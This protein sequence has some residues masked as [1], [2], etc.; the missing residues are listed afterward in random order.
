M[1]EEPISGGS[2]RSRKRKHLCRCAA[3][4]RNLVGAQRGSC[5]EAV[6]G[7]MRHMQLAVPRKKGLGVP[8]FNGDVFEKDAGVRTSASGVDTSPGSRN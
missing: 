3:R 6:E 7:A 1:R 8:E 4:S 5:G 2:L